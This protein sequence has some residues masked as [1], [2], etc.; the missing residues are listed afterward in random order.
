VLHGAFAL[1]VR[2]EWVGTNPVGDGELRVVKGP[3]GAAEQVEGADRRAAEFHRDCVDR[4]EA[5]LAGALD[6]GWP[7]LDVV[8]EIA[9]GDRAAR[10]EA[11]DAGSLVG[12]QLEEFE[13]TG[14]LVGRRDGLQPA[15]IVGEQDARGVDA[16]QFDAAYGEGVQGV[17]DVEVRAVGV[18]ELHRGLHETLRGHRLHRCLLRD[19]LI[20]HRHVGPMD[21]RSSAPARSRAARQAC[22]STASRQGLHAGAV[23]PTKD[24]SD[25]HGPEA[26]AA[27]TC[28]GASGR[29]TQSRGRFHFSCSS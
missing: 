20:G 14:V 21:S 8:V 11:V 3:R 4:R 29:P 25:D 5:V 13:Q 10:A 23:V 24:L 2:W 9:R 22:G 6:E 16:E 1:A 19:R 15:A 18:R 12:L 27:S 7:P 17:G 26:P 28:W